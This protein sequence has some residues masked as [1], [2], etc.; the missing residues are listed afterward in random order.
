MIILGALL[1]LGFLFKDTLKATYDDVFEK[2]SVKD[3]GVSQ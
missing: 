1:G 2:T 3:T